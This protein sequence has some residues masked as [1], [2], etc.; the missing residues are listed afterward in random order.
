[1]QVGIMAG[2]LALV[3]GVIAPHLHYGSKRPICR[4]G[5]QGEIIKCPGS[6]GNERGGVIT[7]HIKYHDHL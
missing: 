3:V 1:M 2:F 5:G 4:E 7:V 6:L